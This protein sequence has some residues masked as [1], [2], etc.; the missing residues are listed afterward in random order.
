MSLFDKNQSL[1]KGFSLIEMMLVMVVVATIL[2]FAVNTL[3]GRSED[4]LVSRTALEI[5]TLLQAS[6]NY[7]TEQQSTTLS[8]WAASQYYGKPLS[9]TPTNFWPPNLNVLVGA[10]L[11]ANQ[12]CSV[13]PNLSSL[14][15]NGHAAYEGLPASVGS[16]A[17]SAS[18]SYYGI[19]LTLPSSAIAVKVAAKVPMSSVSQNKLSAYIPAPGVQYF[20]TQY[21]NRGWI[22]SA[23]ALTGSTNMSPLIK[24]NAKYYTIFMPNC[25]VGYEGHYILTYLK[26]R[27]GHCYQN[28]FGM[29]P[30]AVAKPP[31]VVKHFDLE[32]D[33]NG[34]PQF[35]ANT[36]EY[37]V[38]TAMGNH[39][40]TTA[41]VLGPNAFLSNCSWGGPLGALL[42][43]RDAGYK[44]MYYVAFCVPVGQWKVKTN[45]CTQDKYFNDKAAQCS[46]NWNNYNAQG[47]GSGCGPAST[48]NYY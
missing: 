6:A 39:E 34:S 17:A 12:L 16:G 18:Q 47:G 4:K 21:K 23:G 35:N 3:R 20:P 8:A 24:N 9:S 46:R 5:Q 22:T 10:Y 48:A 25:P 33:Y 43:L 32:L 31:K 1:N 45:Y 13:W 15:C 41:T 7:Y 37:S 27:T 36:G 38:L 40:D 26:Q 30:F 11:Q 44:I 42:S 29:G 2:L 28:K 14:T 19:T